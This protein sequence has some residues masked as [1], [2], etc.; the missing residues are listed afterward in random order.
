MNTIRALVVL[1]SGGEVSEQ[2]LLRINSLLRLDDSSNAQNV[3]IA[4]LD[5][6]EIKSLVLQN[7]CSSVIKEESNKED[8][9]NIRHIRI[10]IPES[11]SIPAILIQSLD[12]IKARYGESCTRKTTP[13]DVVLQMSYDYIHNSSVKMAFEEI[14]KLDDDDLNNVLQNTGHAFSM[15][16]LKY[17]RKIVRSF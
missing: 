2:T 11:D 12:F 9:G 16:F 5:T 17:I 10:E 7:V 4:T 13:V 14:S 6:E 1:F 8:E 3:K 15:S